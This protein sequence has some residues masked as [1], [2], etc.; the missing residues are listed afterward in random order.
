[1]FLEHKIYILFILLKMELTSISIF[2]V[3]LTEHFIAGFIALVILILHLISVSAIGR[4]KAISFN[5]MNQG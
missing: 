5:T 2:L 1:M 3:N 4:D